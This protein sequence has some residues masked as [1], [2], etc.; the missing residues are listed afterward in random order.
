[1]YAS[2]K[3]KK[4]VFRSLA[5]HTRIIE[6]WF[7]TNTNCNLHHA[8]EECHMN[9]PLELQGHLFNFSDQPEAHDANATL[10]TTSPEF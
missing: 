5:S 2:D 6:P 3:K 8:G 7:L 1:M 4:I 9:F 10:P